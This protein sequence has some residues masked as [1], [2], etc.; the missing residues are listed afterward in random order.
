MEYGRYRIVKEGMHNMYVIKPL[1]KGAIPKQLRG[2]YTSWGAAQKAIDLY[3]GSKD[4]GKTGSN[5]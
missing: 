3:E 5:G 2:R 4:N 1:G